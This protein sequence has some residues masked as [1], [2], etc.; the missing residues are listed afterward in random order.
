MFDNQLL[1]LKPWSEGID[2]DEEIFNTSLLWIQ[3][4]HLPIHWYSKT[5]GFK[6]GRI[7]N[8]VQEVLLPQGGGKEGKHMKILAEV[9]ITQPL[10][11]GTQVKLNGVAI[12]AEF[13]YEKCPD[14][15][16]KCGRIGHGEKSCKF[17]KEHRTGVKEEQYG[18]WLRAN[19][20]LASPTRPRESENI[21]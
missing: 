17:D 21:K 11:R 10:A 5:A 16:Y 12:F 4:W 7:F 13:R 18:A 1:V 2:M 19:T 3:I 9:D 20:N 15:C 8:S 6:I 14:F